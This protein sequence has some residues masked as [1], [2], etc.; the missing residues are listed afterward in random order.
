MVIMTLN[1]D[2]VQFIRRFLL[3]RRYLYGKATPFDI[4]KYC[5]FLRVISYMRTATNFGDS[6][7]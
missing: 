5:P 2:D 1:C 6:L 3:K 7:R 4:A